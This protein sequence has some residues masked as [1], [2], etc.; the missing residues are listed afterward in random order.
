[1]KTPTVILRTVVVVVVISVVVVVVVVISVVV[2]VVVVVISVVVVVVISV[3]VVVSFSNI[4]SDMQLQ[5]LASVLDVTKRVEFLFLLAI[6]IL[7]VHI[8]DPLLL[9]GK[10][11]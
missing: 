1:M 10:C 4:G 5:N 8:K 6:Y 11:S 3:V 2:V 7:M 9:I